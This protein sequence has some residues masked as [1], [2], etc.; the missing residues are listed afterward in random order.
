[1]V[2]MSIFFMVIIASKARF[3]SSPPAAIAV[4]W[5]SGYKKAPA[6]ATNNKV[7]A[8]DTIPFAK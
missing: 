5:G 8:F 7:Y 4:Y 6:G 3:A 2:A 1:M